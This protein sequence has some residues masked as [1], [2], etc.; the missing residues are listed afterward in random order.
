MKLSQC[1]VLRIVSY[2]GCFTLK[3]WILNKYFHTFRKICANGAATFPIGFFFYVRLLSVVP[4]ILN[5]DVSL[6]CNVYEILY[7]RVSLSSPQ[8]NVY[9]WFIK[10][11]YTPWRNS[12]CS[13]RALC[14]PARFLKVTPLWQEGKRPHRYTM[15]ALWY[16]RLRAVPDALVAHAGNRTA[17][18]HEVS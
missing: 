5:K 8:R 17:W 2:R 11:S 9:T 4:A 16:C 1:R 12:A 7:F 6:H 10:I 15:V 13:S 18:Y 3:N 14:P